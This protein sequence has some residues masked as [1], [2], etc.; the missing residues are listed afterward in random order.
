MAARRGIPKFVDFLP[1]I[2]IEMTI[3]NSQVDGVVG[4]IRQAART[5]RT[6]DGIFFVSPLK[7]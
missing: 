6:G 7:T 4:A 3:E 1:K 5:G 2:K